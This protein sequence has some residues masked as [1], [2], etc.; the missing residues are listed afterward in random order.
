ML[1][2]PACESLRP[3]IP[4]KMWHPDTAHPT[5]PSKKQK[6]S[7]QQAYVVVATS[8]SRC[9]YYCLHEHVLLRPMCTDC[10]ADM[11]QG[12]ITMNTMSSLI[13]AVDSNDKTHDTVMGI[14]IYVNMHA[15]TSVAL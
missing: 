2:Y 4:T 5:I 9:F 7:L 8:C 14:V 11:H 12:T 10:M 13:A 3:Q 6:T 15:P 1:S